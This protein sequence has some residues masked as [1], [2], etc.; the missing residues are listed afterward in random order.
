[1]NTIEE[2]ACRA[3]CSYASIQATNCAVCGQHKHT[4]LR[5]D[6]MGGYV[7]LTCIDAELQRLQAAGVRQPAPPEPEEPKALASATCSAASYD[8]DQ[9]Y[10]HN[11]WGVRI[12]KRG[13]DYDV[14]EVVK[15]LGFPDEKILGRAMW[16]D[17]AAQ[18]VDEH[19]A[20]IA[21]AVF[22]QDPKPQN[23]DISDPAPKAKQ[24]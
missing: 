24:P 1:M 13:T 4:P 10:R 12:I 16:P 3:G 21:Q 23:V 18:I 20:T 17:Y 15:C 14:A 22:A 6:E 5:N 8:K 19:N 7:C 9:S 2:Q 11:K